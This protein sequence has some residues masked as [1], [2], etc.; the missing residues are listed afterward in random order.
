MEIGNNIV[1]SLKE[2]PNFDIKKISL[3]DEKTLDIFRNVKTDGIFQFESSG[4]KNVLRKFPIKSFK[5]LSVIL[6]LF[7]PGPMDSID[8]YIKRMKALEKIDYIHE[9][10]KPVLEETYGIIV[11]QEQI[12]RIANI[13][14]GF[15]LGEAD[16]LRRAMS[17]KSE[18]L[19]KE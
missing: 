5:D 1:D 6:A 15:S 9:D 3:D 18:K 4:M 11:Y 8:T 10:L 12:M 14:A 16:V 19:M 13:M 17:K 2:I 7:R